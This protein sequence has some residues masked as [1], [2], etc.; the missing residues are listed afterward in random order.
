MNHHVT[1]NL[2][3][4]E[5]VVPNFQHADSLVGYDVK[6]IDIERHFAAMHKNTLE[7]P[8][9]AVDKP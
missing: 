3:T 9:T 6:H 7:P 2:A 1:P 8:F 5:A 4:I